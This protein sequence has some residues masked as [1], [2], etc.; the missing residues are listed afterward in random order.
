M[1]V[2]QNN[3]RDKNESTSRQKKTPIMEIQSG[4]NHTIIRPGR[5]LWTAAWQ[6]ESSI[7]TKR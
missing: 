5:E 4:G 7:I 1:V 6:P 2:D 3:S